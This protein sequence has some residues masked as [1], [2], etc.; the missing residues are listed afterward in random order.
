MQEETK[1]RIY[2]GSTEMKWSH[3]GRMEQIWIRKEIGEELFEEINQ[4]PYTISVLRSK[5]KTLP[6]DIYKRVDIYVEGQKKDLTMIIL[7][8]PSIKYIGEKV[9]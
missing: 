7:K 3:E 6:D 8:Y 2:V 5:S 9:Q 4:G 1:H